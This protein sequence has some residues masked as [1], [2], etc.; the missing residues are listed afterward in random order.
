MEMIRFL[1]AAVLVAGGLFV[2]GVATF[3]LFRLDNALNRLHAAAK[4]DTLGALL[5]LLG[6]AIIVGFNLI[7][8]KL[9]ILVV[10]FWLTNPVAVYM[11][12][13]AEAQ[14]NPRVEEECEVCEVTE[15]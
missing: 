3:G 11:I 12:G 1:V 9:M 10:F 2:L 8:V 15:V 4:C 7:A 13:R 6:L 14:T 5:V